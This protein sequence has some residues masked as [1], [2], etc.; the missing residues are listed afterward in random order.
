N[1]NLSLLTGTNKEF[2][3]S[4]IPHLSSL[5]VN[6]VQKIIDISDVIIINTKGKHVLI[7]VENLPVPFDRRVWQEAN[8][9]KEHGADVSIICPKMKGYTESFEQVNG[10]DI[11]RHPLK[12]GNGVFGYFLEYSTALIWEFILSF[13]IY[14]R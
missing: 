7:I 14:V 9:L 6:D 12:E 10:I 8:T 2:I 1:I 3:N 11:Y 13:K 4:R 5:M